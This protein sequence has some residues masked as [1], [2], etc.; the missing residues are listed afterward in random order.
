MVTPDEVNDLYARAEG[1]I[2]GETSLA[3][4]SQAETDGDRGSGAERLSEVEED[5]RQFL[6]MVESGR[7]DP[8]DFVEFAQ[9]VIYQK[10]LEAE[11]KC[12]EAETREMMK[13]IEKLEAS[14]RKMRKRQ[15]NMRK[16]QRN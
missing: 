12:T 10:Q 14:T 3:G 4:E 1:L 5:L 8:S 11:T 15:E 16:R 13:E 6:D 2:R 9:A 7:A